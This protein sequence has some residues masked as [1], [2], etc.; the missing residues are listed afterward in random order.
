MLKKGLSRWKLLA[1]LAPPW[2]TSHSR[3]SVVPSDTGPAW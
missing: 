3:I 1:R 2:R